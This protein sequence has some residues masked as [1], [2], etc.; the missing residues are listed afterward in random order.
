MSG[1]DA[2][3]DAERSRQRSAEQA[4]EAHAECR[5]VWI[6]SRIGRAD[7]GDAPGGLQAGLE[8]ADTAVIFDAVERHASR[9][10]AKLAKDA[11]PNWPWKARL[12]TV[13][14]DGTPIAL[15]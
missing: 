2:V 14:I 10:Q 1:V 15:P 13:I 7:R 11:A 12:W 3:D 4:V 9:R 6:S 8:E 5:R